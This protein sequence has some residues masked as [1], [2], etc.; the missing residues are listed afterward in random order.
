MTIDPIMFLLTPIVA[1]AAGFAIG[2]NV[3]GR[4]DDSADYHG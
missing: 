1:F 2:R 4:P 3:D